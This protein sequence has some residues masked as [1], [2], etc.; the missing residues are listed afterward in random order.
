VSQ[1]FI[2]CGKF[3]IIHSS[4]RTPWHLF[5]EFLGHVRP[6]WDRE[7]CLDGS[8]RPPVQ[9]LRG[10][11]EVRCFSAEQDRQPTRP[12]YRPVRPCHRDEC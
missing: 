7:M 1:I 11:A 8:L 12:W 5:A 10:L 3:L 9:L 2:D 6:G 4:E